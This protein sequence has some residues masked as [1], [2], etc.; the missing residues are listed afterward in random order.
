LTRRLNIYQGGAMNLQKIEQSLNIIASEASFILHIKDKTEH[1]QALI[2]IERLIEN[3]EQH[4]PLIDLLCMSIE[5]YENTADEFK[6]FNR[7]QS[8]LNLGVKD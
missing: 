8:E 3:Y 6:D 7:R 5:K 1:E 2:L 4:V